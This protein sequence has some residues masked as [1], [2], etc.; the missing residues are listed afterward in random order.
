MTN[1]QRLTEAI[2]WCASV[3]LAFCGLPE[4]L[5]SIRTGE[6]A[7]SYP[8]LLMWWSGETLAIAYVILKSKNVKLWPLM[9]N[10]G[11]N[12]IFISIILFNKFF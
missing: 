9:F 5:D 6:S 8:F 2:G 3:L 7:L 1:K 12:I 10:Y 11:F 4:A